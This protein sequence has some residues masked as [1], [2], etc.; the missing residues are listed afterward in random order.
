MKIGSCVTSTLVCAYTKIQE[1]TR[2]D[3]HLTWWAVN[4]WICA[5]SGFFSDG[6]NCTTEK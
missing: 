5:Y 2:T 6:L 1:I 3:E 4:P